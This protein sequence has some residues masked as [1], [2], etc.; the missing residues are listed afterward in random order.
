M[1]NF[2]YLAVILILLACSDS[3][4][5]PSD[6]LEGKLLILH[7]NTKENI[8]E[9]TDSID[10]SKGSVFDIQVEFN[11]EIIND[12]LYLSFFK[13]PEGDIIAANEF[14]GVSGK[15]FIMLSIS[16]YIKG[17]FTAQVYSAKYSP[18]NGILSRTFTVFN[19]DTIVIEG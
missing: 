7:H 9:D 3:T 10:I 13:M 6:E 4:N 12:S 1:K 14:T 17:T 16:H 19:S 11:Q 15:K 18:V 8:I 5:Q 2:M